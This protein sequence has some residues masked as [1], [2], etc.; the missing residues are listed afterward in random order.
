MAICFASPWRTLLLGSALVL[1]AGCSTL[2]VSS[3]Y[4]HNADFSRF[5][6]YRL[7]SVSIYDERAR[8][9]SDNTL[10]ESRLANTLTAV[11]R[12]KGLRQVKDPKMP[13][14]MRITLL[15]DT[16]QKTQ[17]YATP[18]LMAGLGW[19][20]RPWGWG[21]GY[22]ADFSSR[23]YT[24]GNLRVDMFSQPDNKLV[25]RGWARA[26]LNQPYLDAERLMEAM[27]GVFSGYPP[28]PAP[29]LAP[30]SKP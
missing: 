11:L 14:D 6:T 10:A 15:A 20:R 13:V 27:R 9:D 19:G 3:D 18:N 24:E 23:D 5:Y 7:D 26:E 30:P 12:E 28:A 21:I 22:G 16:R 4:D 25:W 2:K 1:L 29:A 8:L 17:V